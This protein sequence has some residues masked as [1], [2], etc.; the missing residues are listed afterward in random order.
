MKVYDTFSEIDRTQWQELAVQSPTASFFQT[1]ECYEFFAA[2][3]FLKPFVFGVSENNK[4]VGILSGYVT[5][6]GNIIKQYL[7]RRAIVSGGALLDSTIS[8]EALKLLLTVAADALRGK[9]IY[10]EI[11]NYSDYSGY[12]A[13]F[14]SAGFQY[15]PHL[16]FHVP[17][18]DV[19]TSLMNLSTTR[20]REIKLSI[21]AGA[22]W[23]ETTDPEDLRAYYA[24]LLDLYKNKVKTPLFPFE[25]FEKLMQQPFGK[26]FVIKRDNQII[27]GS[28]CVVLPGR[29]MY[30]WFVCGL[31]GQV[32]NVFPSTIAT[33]AAI[34]YAARNGYGCFD[35]MGA[36]KP[37]DGYGV[38]DFKS[39][40]GGELVENGRFLV[41]INPLL[42]KIGKIAVAIMRYQP[43]KYKKTTSTHTTLSG[44]SIEKQLRKI[45]IP[46][47]S[48]FVQKHPNGNIFQTPEMYEV[49]L[50]TPKFYPYILVAK[51][52]N[53]KIEGCLMSV[54]HKDYRGLLGSL[55]ARSIIMGGPLADQ[56]HPEV[57]DVLLRNYNKQ[58]HTRAIY[59]QF[60]NLFNMNAYSGPFKKNGYRLE[61]HLD[62]LIDLKRPE[63]DLENQ[64]HK[65]RKRNIAKAKKQG[66]TFKVLDDEENIK[67]VI[68]LL[69]KTYNRVK[70]PFSYDSMFLTSK[71]ILENHVKFFGAFW[72][73]KM[74][75]GQV[76]LC[77]KDTVY[78]W[79]AGSDSDYFHMRPNDFLLW[80][81]ILWSKENNYTVFDFGGAGKPDVP[82]GVRDY[83][84][85]FGGEL[86]NYGRYQKEHKKFLM[87]FG[88]FAFKLYKILKK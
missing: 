8:E 9:A 58:L 46:E 78:A 66:L 21:K 16:N 23:N 35:M 17:T 19:D 32:K 82:Y 76:R 37:D 20:R 22:V 33:W 26:L 75:A 70:M 73:G 11:R 1:P 43:K 87:Y 60:R 12:K 5:S 65:E 79:Y 48:D 57:L 38:R 40:F 6:D 13:T 71:P 52:K 10:L 83:K 85:K 77:Y 47:W 67:A 24:I 41:Q 62:V 15:T 53:N 30:E 4:L 28:V 80:N 86:V 68:A 63:E 54:I 34:E 84:L 49:Y 42:F 7:S 50:K 61:E 2:F 3:S 29:I 88:R 39:K 44:I 74:I 14:E 36:G 18:P 55:T 72:E 64:L 51:D 81:V 27:G 25:F 69:K 31:D 59:S 56:D 45:N